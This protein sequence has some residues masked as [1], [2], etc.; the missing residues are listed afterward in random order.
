MRKAS[1]SNSCLGICDSTASRGRSSAADA[2]QL[3]QT[4]FDFGGTRFHARHEIDSV[5]PPFAATGAE[6][7]SRAHCRI[8]GKHVT[9]RGFSKS[10]LQ[11]RRSTM[12]SAAD[13]FTNPSQLRN[14]LSQPCTRRMIGSR[15]VILP[16]DTLT[17]STTCVRNP[18]IETRR[19]YTPGSSG[20]L[21]KCPVAP[22][23]IAFEHH[24][25]CSRPG[26]LHF[27]PSERR[28]RR[29]HNRTMNLAW[30]LAQKH[31]EH[32]NQQHVQYSATC[33]GLLC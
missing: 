32:S 25:R 9:A 1:P 17:S 27:G 20:P 3:H 14:G 28:A 33:V 4:K 22:P 23:V 29:I 5:R 11:S 21:R 19:P 31:R 8:V 12:S 26:N 2:R 24:I 15:C 6:G 16:F 30:T 7:E 13:L 10:I 18:A